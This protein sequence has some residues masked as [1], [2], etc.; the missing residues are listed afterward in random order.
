MNKSINVVVQGKSCFA[1]KLLCS[2]TDYFEF[3]PDRILV[4]GKYC[5]EEEAFHE[6]RANPKVEFVTWG[7]DDHK[8]SSLREAVESRLKKLGPKTKSI[9][10]IDDLQ[11]E[12]RINPG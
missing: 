11:V 4:F 10:L 12:F 1:A 3:D 8:Q 7:A 2:P 5:S 9:V 6:L